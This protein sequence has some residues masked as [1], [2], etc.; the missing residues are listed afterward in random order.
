MREELLKSIASTIQDYR[1]GEIERITP[2]H[3]DKWVRQFKVGDQVTILQEMNHIL[4][5]KHFYLSR[6]SVKKYVQRFLSNK[7]L[8]GMDPK[9]SLIRTNFLHIQQE[10]KSQT[11]IIKVIDEVLFDDYNLRISK[12]GGSD[13]YAYV[14][15][16]LFS[17]NRL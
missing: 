10:G 2:S 3:V 17:G 11:D 4:K 1:S 9:T 6:D 7:E 12:C 15:D 5:L 8:F 16:G 13:I 14:D